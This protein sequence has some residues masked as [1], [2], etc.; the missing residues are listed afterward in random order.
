MAAIPALVVTGPL[1]S[2][3]TTVI[4]RLLAGKP[5]HENWVV[6]LNE[7]SDAGV[8]TLTVAAAAR[9]AYDVRLVPGGCLCCAGEQD[10]RRNLHE[11]VTEVRPARIIV[12][13]S[14]LGHPAGIV[15]ELLAHEARGALRLDAVLAVLDAPRV[16]AGEVVRGSLAFDQAEI[17][18]ALALT[19]ADLAD[20][21]TRQR[22][23]AL[24]QAFFP[25][26]RWSGVALH[27]AVDPQAFER[28]AAADG[29]AR[30]ATLARP[31]L[32]VAELDALHEHE[33]PDECR[34]AGGRRAVFRHLGHSAAR[35]IFPRSVAFSSDRL[36]AAVG[37]AV[38]A[39]AAGAAVVRVKG[40][41]RVAEDAYVLAQH[42]GRAMQLD[43]S[44]WR[45]DNRVEVLVEGPADIDWSRWD[46]LWT[47]CQAAD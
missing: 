27:G 4:A 2:G 12:E 36:A 19:K 5:A 6:L 28:D 30:R 22:F 32:H 21:A 35:W 41:F 42:D 8:D 14:G 44:S 23:D 7:F 26:K 45:R 31:E 43:A 33:M 16:A 10:F 15:E 18:D 25:A 37:V 11:L 20:A 29:S 38:R 47:H 24:A 40:V 34:A 17:A 9:G 3:K 1:G 46:Q 39:T 13:P